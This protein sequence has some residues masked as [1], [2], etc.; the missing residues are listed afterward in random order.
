MMNKLFLIL[1]VFAAITIIPV[2]YAQF[3]SFLGEPAYQKSI[4][5]TVDE[6]ENIQ[7]KHSIASSNNPV[8]VKLFEDAIPD[9]LSVTNEDGEKLEFAIIGFGN[10][11]GAITILSTNENAIIEYD[12]ENIIWQSDSILIL[13]IGYPETFSILFFEK[14]ELIFLNNNL[15]QLGDQK[16]IK[17]HGGGYVNVEYYSKVPKIIQEIQWKEDKFNVEIITDAEID[18]F[19]FDQAAKSISFEI[20]EKNKFLTINMEKELLGGPYVILFNNEQI[21][22]NQHSINEN[23]ISLNVKPESTGEIIIIGT[24]VIPEF[25]MFIPLIMGFLIVLTVPFMKKFSLH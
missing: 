2:S 6:L 1:V 16:G 3:G 4:E 15:I 8:T 18:K 22:Y 24:T 9:T 14:T 20:N 11:E 17:I 7:A 5:I 21:K 10:N 19:N 12:L 23:Y 25:S 13:N